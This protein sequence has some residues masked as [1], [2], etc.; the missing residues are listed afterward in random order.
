MAKSGEGIEKDRAIAAEA[1]N[2]IAD[3]L[4]RS[5]ALEDRALAEQIAR[6][7][8]AWFAIDSKREPEAASM[9]ER[10]TR[11]EPSTSTLVPKDREGMSRGR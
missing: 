9:R 4:S 6:F 3:G 7:A 1:W 2:R 10:G 8:G 11:I 5:D